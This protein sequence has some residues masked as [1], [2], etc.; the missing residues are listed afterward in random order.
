MEQNWNYLIHLCTDDTL[1]GY[2][3]HRLRESKLKVVQEGV[4]RFR[5]L[6]KIVAAW[7]MSHCM[8]ASWW[9]TYWWYWLEGG[10]FSLSGF[11]FTNVLE[12]QDCR[13]KWEGIPLTTQYHFDLLHRHLHINQLITAKN[14]PSP[15]ASSRTQTGN[16]WLP[17]ASC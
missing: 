10:F 14:S 2:G 3:V 7:S 16:L 6:F 12:S 1:I 13:R 9:E 15:I 17:S 4:I 5:E 11:S 8:R